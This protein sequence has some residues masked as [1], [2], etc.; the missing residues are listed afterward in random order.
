MQATYIGGGHAWDYGQPARDQDIRLGSVLR[1]GS[2]QQ[3][4]GPAMGRKSH[5][6]SGGPG[7]GERRSYKLHT[8]QCA[9]GGP[10]T[11]TKAGPV[12]DTAS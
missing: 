11:L 2:E 5:C 8:V 9:C 12:D 10:G 4:S 3:G 1:L 7:S 6:S